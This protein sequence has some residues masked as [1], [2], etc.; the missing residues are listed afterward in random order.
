MEEHLILDR[1]ARETQKLL[2]GSYVAF[3]SEQGDEPMNN[4]AFG[5]ALT[6]QLIGTIEGPNGRTKDKARDQIRF[7]AR[8]KTSADE[9]IAEPVFQPNTQSMGEEWPQSSVDRFEA[10]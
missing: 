7:G 8:L 10:V 2:Y 6:N 5:K 4:R 9:A 1:E 3:C